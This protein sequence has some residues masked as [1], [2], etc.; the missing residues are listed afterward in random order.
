M[1]L[2]FPSELIKLFK[3]NHLLPSLFFASF[4]GTL[5]FETM[6]ITINNLF[7]VLGIFSGVFCASAQV[8]DYKDS[9]TDYILFDLSIPEGQNDVAYA[10]GAQFTANSPG[11]I[12]KSTDGGETWELN[13]PLTGTIDGLEKI[14]FVSVDKGFAVGYD[15][16][17]KTEDGGGTWTPITVGTD[18]WRYN[19]LTF[20]NELIGYATAFTNSSGFQTYLTTDGGDTWTQGTSSAN[21]GTIAV[22]YADETTL[23]STGND[24]VI[25]KSTDSGNTWTVI[26]NGTPTFVNLEVAFS[27]LENGMVS[28]EDGELLITHDSGDTWTSFSTGYHNFYG[29]HYEGSEL[30]AAGTD[31]DIYYSSDDGETWAVL[32]NGENVATFYEIQFFDNNSALICGSQG[33]MLKYTPVLDTPAIEYAE[34]DIV[35]NQSSQ[36][37]EIRSPNAAIREVNLYSILG[38]IIFKEMLTPTTSTSFNVASLANGLY[39]VNVVTNDS[40]VSKKFLKM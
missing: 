15:L 29:L 19:N 33:R 24:Q 12:I 18:I 36:S 32:H 3:H 9:G 34:V 8:W 2:Y 35:Y 14:E 26:R 13:Y 25:S 23:F 20:Y 40:S 7:C 30:Y 27:D 21:M 16:F 39:L 6:R 38:Q 10:A 4:V 1:V 28:G 17:L 31:Q 22:G 5:N 37:L 11:I